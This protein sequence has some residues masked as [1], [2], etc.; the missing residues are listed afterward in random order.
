MASNL[1][2]TEYNKQTSQIQAKMTVKLERGSDYESQLHRWS[3]LVILGN[4]HFF[5]VIHVL[6]HLLIRQLNHGSSFKALI[7]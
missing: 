2:A 3:H 6:V 4:T 5:V 1:I 7:H